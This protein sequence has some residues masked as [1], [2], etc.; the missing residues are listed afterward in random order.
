[1]VTHLRKINENITLGTLD[2]KAFSLSERIRVKRELEKAG[3]QYLLK[4]MLDGADFVLDYT[5][6]N[7][8]FIRDSNYHLSI[9]HSH[10]KLAI[11]LNRQKNTGIDIELLRDKILRVRHKFLNSKEWTFAQQNVQKLITIWAAKEAMYKAHGLKGLDFKEHLSV[12]DF[13]SI[14][15]SGRLAKDGILKEY[16]LISEKMEEYIM[17]Y[18]LD[19]TVLSHGL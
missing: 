19:E 3:A 2:L 6:Q 8:P 11:I 18:I 16:R 10:D 17:V 9:S 13:S 1:M 14:H 7:K 15:I 4:I 5:P 12:D